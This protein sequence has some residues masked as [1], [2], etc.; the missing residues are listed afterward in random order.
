MELCRSCEDGIP[1]GMRQCWRQTAWG[2]FL[3][4]RQVHCR[5]RPWRHRRA[6]ANREQ[7]RSPS[8][9]WP[10]HIAKGRSAQVAKRR[11]RTHRPLPQ[12]RS[13]VLPA[14]QHVACA[15]QFRQPHGSAQ[16]SMRWVS[17]RVQN[18]PK[19]ARRSAQLRG[20]ADGARWPNIAK[21][22]VCPSSG[23][24]P[25]MSGRIGEKCGSTKPALDTV[26]A[27]RLRRTCRRGGVRARRRDAGTC[28][29]A[30]K[31]A[32]LPEPRAPSPEPRAPSPEPRAPRDANWSLRWTIEG[33]TAWELGRILGI[34]EH[35]AVR[36]THSAT[37]KLGCVNKHQAVLKALRLRLIW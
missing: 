13:R 32:G 30:A 37:K 18:C 25:P 23:I 21:H 36:H 9:H 29:K 26:V 1:R 35:T 28:A 4:A 11:D 20:R 34:A 33:K 7:S 15:C 27:F 16:V 22:T 6:A 14:S 5:G 31:G 19:Q 3:L 12:I 10:H 17:E 8:W 24:R 2:R